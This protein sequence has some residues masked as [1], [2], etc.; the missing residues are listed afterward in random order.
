MINLKTKILRLDFSLSLKIKVKPK[1][2]KK[3]Q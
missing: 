1:H 3:G 2:T